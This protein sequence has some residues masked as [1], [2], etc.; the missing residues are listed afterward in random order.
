[1]GKSQSVPV[2]EQQAFLPYTPVLP[3]EY[4]GRGQIEDKSEGQISRKD[5]S[6]CE[7]G[8]KDNTFNF[9]RKVHDQGHILTF[10]D[11]GN[12]DGSL[13]F[14]HRLKIRPGHDLLP[15]LQDAYHIL[16]YVL[17]ESALYSQYVTLPQGHS[18]TTRQGQQVS[19]TVPLPKTHYNKLYRGK[20]CQNNSVKSSSVLKMREVLPLF[21]W[22]PVFMLLKEEN[23]EESLKYGQILVLASRSHELIPLIG[24]RPPTEEWT[25]KWKFTE[26]WASTF[27]WRS[28]HGR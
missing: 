3:I 23:R 5:L 4:L 21:E 16:S 17:N 1:M 13:T 19:E 27:L 10:R 24:G 25:E 15:W 14:K 18:K 9:G 11:A 8:V 2:R 22:I 28:K 7:C 26:K 20:L 12:M 6:F